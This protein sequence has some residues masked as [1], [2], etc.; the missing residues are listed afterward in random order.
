MPPEQA[1]ERIAQWRPDPT[2]W[3]V[4]AVELARTLQPLVK[5]NP[6]GWVSEPVTIATTL[7]QPIYIS[8]YLQ[9]VAEV[10]DDTLLPVGDLL[11]VIQ[12]V[13]DELWPAA[14]LGRERLDYD[15]D[16]RGAQRSAVDL[17]RALVKADADFGDRTDE[18]W[19]VVESAARNRSD[20]SWISNETDPLTRALNRSCTRAFE[21]A[22]LFVAAELRAAHPVRSAFEDLLSFALR[23]EDSD[24][25]E[26]RAVL[27]PRIAWLRHTL[28]EWTSTNLEGLFPKSSHCPWRKKLQRRPSGRTPHGQTASPKVEPP[29]AC[30]HDH[31]LTAPAPPYIR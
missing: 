24:G 29:R 12:M 10:A 4:S 22:I 21:T 16:W 30:R 14:Q 5:D 9:A 13:R 31:H 1:A 11:D 23:L 2:D 19:E 18:A 20:T 17:I 26:Y 25:A 7:R 8:H 6:G 28:P 27:A 3:Y 15:V